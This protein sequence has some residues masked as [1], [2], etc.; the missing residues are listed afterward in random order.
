MNSTP[1]AIMGFFTN[2]YSKVIFVC[3]LFSISLWNTGCKDTPQKPNTPTELAYKVIKEWQNPDG[4]ALAVQI[5]LQ[6]D[7]EQ[8]I[9]FAKKIAKEKGVSNLQ[10]YS[11]QEA[12]Q[13]VQDANQNDA[14]R[15][16]F[17]FIFKKEGNNNGE[18][19]WMQEDGKL[20]P[21]VNTV[22]KLEW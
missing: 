18:I 22:T 13:A 6:A 10:A 5:S 4:K 7:K 16:G 15:K 19:W 9:A 21:L 8:Y 3:L 20:A 1:Y 14:F 2:R 11:S 12:F 17:L